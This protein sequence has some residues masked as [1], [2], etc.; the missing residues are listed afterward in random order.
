MAAAAVCTLGGGAHP[1]QLGVG[2][3]PSTNG[4]EAGLSFVNGVHTNKGGSHVALLSEAVSKALASVLGKAVAADSGS[5]KGSAELVTPAL[6][7][8]TLHTNNA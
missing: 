4:P 6:V 5:A 2:F 3:A 1:W 8:L 7:K